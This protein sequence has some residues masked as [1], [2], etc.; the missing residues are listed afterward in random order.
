MKQVVNFVQTH[1]GMSRISIPT[2]PLLVILQF[3]TQ[4]SGTVRMTW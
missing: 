3:M 2:G 4:A 1:L